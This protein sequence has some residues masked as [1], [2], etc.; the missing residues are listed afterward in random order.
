MDKTHP[1][2]HNFEIIPPGSKPIV[3]STDTDL[4]VSE[5]TFMIPA[6]SSEPTIKTEVPDTT[7]EEEQPTKRGRFDEC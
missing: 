2:E 1:G 5:E 3:S 4:F 6:P 7:Q